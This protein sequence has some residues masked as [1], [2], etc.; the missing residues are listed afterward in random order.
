[1]SSLAMVRLVLLWPA[2]TLMMSLSPISICLIVL[3]TSKGSVMVLATLPATAPLTKLTMKLVS[4]AARLPQ[5][6]RSLMARYRW[7]PS[8]VASYSGQYSAEKGTSLSRVAV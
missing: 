6:R 3:I 1:M 8:L 4:A 5:P 2:V 7:R